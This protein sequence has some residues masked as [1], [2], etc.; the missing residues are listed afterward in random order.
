MH[1]RGRMRGSSRKRGSQLGEIRYNEI[2]LMWCLAKWPLAA[3]DE[4]GPHAIRLCANAIESMIGNKQ[5]A[6]AVMTNDLFCFRIGLP[7]R[8][9]IPG[10]LHRNHVIERKANVRSGAIEHV[11]VAICQ[12]CQ[13]ISLAPNLLDSSDNIGKRFQPLNFAHEPAHLLLCVSNATAIH[14]V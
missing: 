1:S 5:N 6:G 7:V 8:L 13:L 11:S 4:G 3:V 12:N 2:R 14:D 10:F 9:E